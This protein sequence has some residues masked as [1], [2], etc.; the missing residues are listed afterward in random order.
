MIDELAGTGDTI[1]FEG[2]TTFGTYTIVAED[3]ITGCSS[4]MDGSFTMEYDG[5]RRGGGMGRG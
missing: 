2:Q 1:V 5:E 4:I 3:T